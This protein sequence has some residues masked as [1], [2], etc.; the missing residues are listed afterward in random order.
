MT[1]ASRLAI[2]TMGYR[3]G[4]GDGSGPHNRLVVV[5]ELS[6]IEEDL[7]LIAL[8]D[9]I[10]LFSIESDDEI[11]SLDSDFELLGMN[12]SEEIGISE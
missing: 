9:D 12:E 10:E 11:Y 7:E 8:D 3:G 5:S 1:A 2:A 4:Q 6:P